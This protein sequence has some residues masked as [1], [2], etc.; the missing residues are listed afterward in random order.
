LNKYFDLLKN[1]NLALKI[2]MSINFGLLIIALMLMSLIAKIHTE[3]IVEITI[4]PVI[5]ADTKYKIGVN[6]ANEN[7]FNTWGNLFI[8]NI[9][10]YN[11]SDFADKEKSFLANVN[12]SRQ[13]VLKQKLDEEL[14]N[15]INS[16]IDNK[17]EPLTSTL[18]VLEP[19]KVNKLGV[20]GKLYL[21]REKGLLTRTIAGD[22]IHDKQNYIVDIV[23]GVNFGNISIYDLNR[24][25]DRDDAK[26]QK[27]LKKNKAKYLD[28][29][30]GN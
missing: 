13:L 16:R 4:P 9:S 2:S 15:V 23:L 20:S 30:E 11:F 29:A 7:T 28:S 14:V 21:Y 12:L 18:T 5:S 24:Y 25:F 26:L 17:F 1:A 8:S 6:D 3:K 19:M 22:L 27:E 10:N